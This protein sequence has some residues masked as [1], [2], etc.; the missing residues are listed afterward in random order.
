MQKIQALESKLRSIH[1]TSRQFEA[2][3]RFYVGQ[4]SAYAPRPG[5]NAPL[6]MTHRM[7]TNAKFVPMSQV[8]CKQELSARPPCG[9]RCDVVLGVGP[10]SRPSGD[11]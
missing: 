1:S 4:S 5:K 6:L 11:F 2:K 3:L 8:G 10:G 7:C 9:R